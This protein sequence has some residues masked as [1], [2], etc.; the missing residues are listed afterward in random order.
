MLKLLKA[1]P[2]K[3]STCATSIP[4]CELK[5]TL[6]RDNFGEICE[7]TVFLCKTNSAIF[8]LKV[9]NRNNREQISQIT[10][11]LCKTFIRIRTFY[12]STDHFLNSL[13]T[14]DHSLPMTTYVCVTC[15]NTTSV[16]VGYSANDFAHIPLLLFDF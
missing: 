10:V 4:H 3:R 11:F 8:L 13:F 12:L 5:C 16:L 7:I 1:V 6:D 2:T 9:F 14:V 15:Y